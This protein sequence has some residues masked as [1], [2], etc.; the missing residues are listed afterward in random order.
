MYVYICNKV[1][2]PFLLTL[3][4]IPK[5]TYMS[6]TKHTREYMYTNFKKFAIFDAVNPLKKYMRV[7]NQSYT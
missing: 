1:N 7:E 5:N 2:F 3:G 6:K 4:Y